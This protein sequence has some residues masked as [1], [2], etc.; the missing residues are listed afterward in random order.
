MI[1][2]AKLIMESRTAAG[3]TQADLARRAGTSQPYLRRERRVTSAPDEQQEAPATH[4]PFAAL[5]DLLKG[6]KQK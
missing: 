1:L 2:S 6:K 5:G 4:R 3:L